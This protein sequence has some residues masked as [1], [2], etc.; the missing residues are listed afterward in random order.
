MKIIPLGD[1][2]LVKRRTVG[3]KLG[4]SGLLVSAD[5]TKDRP[6]DLADVV[7]IPDHSFGD[8]QLINNAAAIITSLTT[9]AFEGD[10]EA[11]RALIDFNLFL[12]IK[13]IKPGDTVM[14]SKYIGTDFNTQDSQELITLVRGDD[15]M[16]ILK[17]DKK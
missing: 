16:C 13:S 3:E 1:R 2:I 5:V 15:I 14:I 6:T 11:L 4:T 17:E 7:K 12:K 8:E 10:A 9:K